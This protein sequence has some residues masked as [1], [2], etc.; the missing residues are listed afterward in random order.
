MPLKF[1]VALGA[2][3]NYDFLFCKTY[4]VFRRSTSVQNTINFKTGIKIPKL[5]NPKIITIGYT[6]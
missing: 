5:K 1:V 3:P 2:R 4:S 6:N